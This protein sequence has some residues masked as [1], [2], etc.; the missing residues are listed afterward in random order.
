MEEDPKNFDENEYKTYMKNPKKLYKMYKTLIKENESLT[1]KNKENESIIRQI[2][3]EQLYIVNKQIYEKY[4]SFQSNDIKMKEEIVQNN[5]DK[6]FTK[7]KD[8]INMIDIKSD[9]TGSLENHDE[10]DND[11][12]K[13]LDPKEINNII[14]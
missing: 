7:F 11:D 1:K 13:L 3:N 14:N 6:M 5:S 4:D 10:S 8:Y 2:T 12:Q 9:N